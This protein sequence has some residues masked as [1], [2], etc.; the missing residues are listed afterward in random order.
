MVALAKNTEPSPPLKAFFD[1]P[2][3]VELP[4]DLVEQIRSIAQKTAGL[5]DDGPWQD[6]YNEVLNLAVKV[7]EELDNAMERLHNEALDNDD[8]LAIK[9]RAMGEPKAIADRTRADMR[10]AVQSTIQEWVDRVG[11]QHDQV[12]DACMGEAQNSVSVHAEES[13]ESIVFSVDQTWWAQY[14]GY[15]TR[16]CEQWTNSTIDKIIQDLFASVS[17]RADAIA[18]ISARQL[19]PVPRASVGSTAHPGTGQLPIKKVDVPTTLG[20]VG[21]F[22][23]GNLTMVGMVAMGLAGAIALFDHLGGG[24][25]GGRTI[26]SMAVRGGLMLLVIPFSLIFGVKATKKERSKIIEK[27]KDEMEQSI[28]NQIRSETGHAL[29]RQRQIIVNWIATVK[30][31][32]LSS[33]DVWIEDGVRSLFLEKEQEATEAIRQARLKQAKL[34]E[35]ISALR[36]FKGQFTNKHLVDLKRRHHELM[37]EK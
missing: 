23:R 24:A 33:L 36:S 13:K 1:L 4:D 2:F 6:I 5:T 19:P 31:A 32:Y 8:P 12:L 17:S 14:S 22:L 26:S 35:Q 20:G 15:V 34:N 11:R 28:K 7:Q 3:H 21:K 30:D 9:S 25:D 18:Q 27:A 10:Q 29:Q 37:T 16:A